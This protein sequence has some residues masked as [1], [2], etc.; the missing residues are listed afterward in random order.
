MRRRIGD[1]GI[2][3]AAVGHGVVA[4]LHRHRRHRRHRLDTFDI[5]F[6]Q[7]LDKSQNGVELALEVFDFV[8][9]NRYARQMRNAADGLGVNGHRRPQKS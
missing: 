2:R 7:L 9:R 8:I 5:D 6:R 4:H 3:N 1:D